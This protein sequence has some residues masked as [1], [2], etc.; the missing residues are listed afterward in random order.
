MDEM[1]KENERHENLV[2]EIQY[3]K[4]QTMDISDNKI[5][6]IGEKLEKEIKIFG[7][8]NYGLSTPVQNMITF[9]RCLGF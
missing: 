3:F 2:D 9:G 8:V 5:K 6:Q 4:A 1:K 7:D